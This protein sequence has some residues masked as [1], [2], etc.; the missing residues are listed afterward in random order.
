MAFCRTQTTGRLDRK[1]INS[2]MIAK[3]YF[4]VVLLSL[5]GGIQ[6]T[7]AQ[8]V[9]PN[10]KEIIVI[11]K[12]HF[13]LGYTHRAKDIVQ[14][15]RTDMIDKALEIMDRTRDLPK[16]QQFSWTAPGW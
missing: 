8:T 4:V 9:N 5:L 2:L 10:V 7:P 16:E 1:Q 13:D 12:T 11:F 3:K 14:F 15:Y 6:Q